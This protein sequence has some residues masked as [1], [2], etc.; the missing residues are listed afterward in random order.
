MTAPDRETLERAIEAAV[1]Y[2]DPC[3]KRVLRHTDA[4]VAVGEDEYVEDLVGSIVDVIL[5]LLPAPP[6]D[7]GKAG[8]AAERLRRVADLSDGKPTT[9]VGGAAFRVYATTPGHVVGSAVAAD[10]RLLLADRDRLTREVGAARDLAFRAAFADEEGAATQWGLVY[11]APDGEETSPWQV[12]DEA[13]AR[14][15]LRTWSQGDYNY[16]VRRTVGPWKPAPGG[17]QP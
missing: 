7:A 8:E 14:G 9:A 17:G 12:A 1:F 6:P 15:A 3:G 5:P 13:L 16:V 11:V 10:L 4:R 2:T